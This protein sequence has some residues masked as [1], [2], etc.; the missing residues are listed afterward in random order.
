MAVADTIAC[1][2]LASI[3]M[4]PSIEDIARQLVAPNK[5]ILAADESA[6]TMQKRLDSIGVENTTENGRRFRGLL[7][8]TPNVGEH[9]SGVIMYDATIRQNANDGTPYAQLLASKGIT[10]GIKV[11]LGLVPLSEGSEEEVSQGLDTLD[12][13]LAE[14]YELGARFTKWRS[15][16]RISDT[17][18]TDEALRANAEVLAKYAVAVQ[19]HGMVPMV[20]PEVLFDGTHTLERSGDVIQ[21]TLQVL[22]DALE[23]HQVNLS[24][25]ILKTS[26]A[27]PGKESGIPLD[28]DAIAGATV[29]ALSASVPRAV[30]GI[31]FLS[32]GQTPTQATDNLNAIAQLGA[33]AWPITF[34]YSRALEEPVLTAWRGLDENV[35][36]AQSAFIDCLTRTVAARNGA[37]VSK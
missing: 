20:E 30:A 31:V 22:F 27:L 12:A 4:T 23:A 5:G 14:Y 1:I 18:P 34:S 6:T 13:R 32:G 15:V 11:D 16:I 19:A 35:E 36:T 3:L 7:F 2:F 26:M 24:G 28:P 29:S 8:T 17:L 37:Y 10:P 9:L 25:L 21:K 33:Q